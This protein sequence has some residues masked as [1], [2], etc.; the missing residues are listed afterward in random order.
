MEP[1]FRQNL[2]ISDIH[3]APSGWMKPSAALFFAQE[4]AGEHCIQLG[5]DWQAMVQKGLFWAIIRNRVRFHRLPRG[6]ETIHLETWPMP[7]T[8]V[9]YPRTVVAFDEAGL[10]V[11][12]VHS[13]WVLMD[14]ASRAMVMPGK[15]GVVVDGIL[16]GNEL[17]SPVSIP[18][19]ILQP[20]QRRSV[21]R[22]DLDRNGHM[23]NVRYLDWL[24]E[25]LPQDKK[26]AELELV[27][28]AESRENDFL[29]LGWT[30]DADNVL[31]AEITRKDPVDGKDHRIF[32]AR[33]RYENNI[34]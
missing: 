21:A 4:I 30:Q 22:E 1:I 26:M 19:A 24:A 28:F 25:L 18:Q 27:Y 7:T 12:E 23:N 9:A 17:P 31:H 33:I 34:M 20:Q 16:R 11:F 15:S 32:A 29:D 13:L 3:L 2:T 8:R 6:G 10:P 14:I 5:A